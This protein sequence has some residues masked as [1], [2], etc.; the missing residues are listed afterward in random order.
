ML[1][2]THGKTAIVDDE[3][4]EFLN[5]WKWHARAPRAPHLPWYA[6]RKSSPIYAEGSK[7]G[8][9][10][11]RRKPIRVPII[12]MHRLIMRAQE[13]QEVDHI[14]RDGL[15]NRRCNLRIATRSEQMLNARIKVGKS[16]VRGVTFKKRENVWIAR[17][18]GEKGP[19]GRIV[20]GRF[21]T[22]E[23]ACAARKRYEEGKQVAS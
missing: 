11:G 16:G 10:V 22:F 2:L 4:F 8:R 14:N 1:T 9:N 12:L 7:K 13:D 15:D 19:Y 17:F 6:R 3:D 21:K 5:Q 23:E 20:I 18:G